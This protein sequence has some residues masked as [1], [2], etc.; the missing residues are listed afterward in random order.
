M[1]KDDQFAGEQWKAIEYDN[2]YQ[3]SSYGRFRKKL[4]NG[5]RYLTPFKKHNLYQVK[6]KDKDINCAR[7]VANAFIKEL[8]DNDRV[9]HI[10]KNNADNFYRNLKILSKKELGKLTGAN[11]KSQSVI[12]IK[13][14]EIEVL[15]I[16]ENLPTVD[17][18]IVYDSHF[19]TT[20]PKKFIEDY[21]DYKLEL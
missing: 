21:I 9:Y 20:A 15:K 2:R 6:I 18:N 8:E 16:K 1:R 7:L 10:N 13:N 19:L 17:I 4:K 14:N 11:S 5:Y 12:E 3:V